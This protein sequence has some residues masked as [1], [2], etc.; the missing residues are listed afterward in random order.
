MTRQEIARRYREKNRER[1]RQEAARYR[2]ENR[3]A[4]RKAAAERRQNED[5]EKLRERWRANSRRKGVKPRLPGHILTRL[6][7]YVPPEHVD[8]YRRMVK[9][10]GSRVAL[11]ALGLL[12]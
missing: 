11:E 12:P 2:E 4:I 5:P 8:E 3:E 10:F 1:L 9:H 7:V 6:G